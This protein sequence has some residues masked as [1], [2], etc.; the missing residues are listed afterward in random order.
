[1]MTDLLCVVIRGRSPGVKNLVLKT[2]VIA[3]S[4]TYGF[5]REY[6]EYVEL[7]Q[8]GGIAVKGLTA[9]AREGNPVPRIVET[10]M[11]ILNSI[12]LQNPG[13]EG[14]IENELPWLRESGT[15]VIA[16]I[17]GNTPDEFVAMATRLDEVQGVHALEVNVSCPN[18][19]RG[20]EVFA[21]NPEMV[22]MITAAVRKA[23][24]LP[25]IVKLSPNVTDIGLIAEKAE[26]G[27][28]DAVSLI[29]T[30]LGMAVDIQSQRPVLTNIFGGL[31]GPAVKPIALRQVWQVYDAVS[32][33]IIGMGGISNAEDALEFL[34]AGASAV[35]IGTGNFVNPRICV[36]VAAGIR[37]Y[38]VEKG[39]TEVSQI[40]GLAHHH[41]RAQDQ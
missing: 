17:S 41:A 18:L 30:V 29:N 9:D 15:A 36:D 39:F 26:A 25:L 35:S 22:E 33:P 10:P 34:M 28:A 38:M 16:N 32:V 12:G 3:A 27:G 4:G 13:I 1:M 11:G 19:H 20:G 14:F 8:L 21:T 5:G 40:S 6:G 2:P 7:Q 24:S 23:T 31:S 37:A